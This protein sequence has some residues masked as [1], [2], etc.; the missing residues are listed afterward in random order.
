MH[1]SDLSDSKIQTEDHISGRRY[2]RFYQNG[3]A[4]MVC[5]IRCGDSMVL[6]FYGVRQYGAIVR[7]IFLLFEIFSSPYKGWF[8]N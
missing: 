8:L 4:T 6:V 5:T 7:R 3:A 1:I 2:A